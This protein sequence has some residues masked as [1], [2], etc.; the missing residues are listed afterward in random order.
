[1]S[2]NCFDNALILCSK[3]NALIELHLFDLGFEVSSDCG[4]LGMKSSLVFQEII[5]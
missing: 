2:N 4:R 5:S 3:C 1:M